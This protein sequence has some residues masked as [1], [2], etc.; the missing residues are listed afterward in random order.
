MLAVLSACVVPLCLTCA[1]VNSDTPVSREQC[2]R[3]GHAAV[4]LMWVWLCMAATAGSFFASA[5][6]APKSWHR[7]G[8]FALLSCSSFVFA[9][10]SGACLVDIERW[11][12]YK[13]AGK[14]LL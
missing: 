12:W 11:G 10:I 13:L 1:A 4:V 14:L 8:W 2:E 3:F 5:V 7:A 6:R 9:F